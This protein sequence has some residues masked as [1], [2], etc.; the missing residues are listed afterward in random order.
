MDPAYTLAD[1]APAVADYL[2]LRTLAGL[3]TKSEAQAAA[4]VEGSWTAVHV[5]EAATART[6]GMGRVIGD[7]GWYFHIVD[8]AVLPDHQR[9]GI[10]DAILRELVNRIRSSAPNEPYVTLLADA[11]G[12]R[13]YERHGF[14]ETAPASIGMVQPRAP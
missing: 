4:A 13:L 9:R 14:V 2:Q 5:V 8:M 1:G 6:V 11:P 7:G 3:S 10:G 12:R